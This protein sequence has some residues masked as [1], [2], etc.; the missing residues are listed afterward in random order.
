MFVFVDFFI[1]VLSVCF[2]LVCFVL[3]VFCVVFF[4]FCGYF[5]CFCLC[6]WCV[7]LFLVCKEVVEIKLFLYL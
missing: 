6:F 2:F 5:Y 3:L 4:V 7:W 1:S